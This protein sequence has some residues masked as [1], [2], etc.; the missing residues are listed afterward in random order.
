MVKDKTAEND[1]ADATFARILA[2]GCESA[3][4][5]PYC[6]HSL[7]AACHHATAVGREGNVGN[8]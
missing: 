5:A 8:R 3:V 2:D 4:G 7:H 6:A 1:L